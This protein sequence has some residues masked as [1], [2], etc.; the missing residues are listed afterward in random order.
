MLILVRYV[1]LGTTIAIWT[2]LGFLCWV[3]LLV[4]MTASF[5]VAILYCTLTNADSSYL[6]DPLDGAITFYSRGFSMIITIL[7]PNR[8][9]LPIGSRF[10]FQG[11]RVL[12]EIAWAV[13]FWASILFLFLTAFGWL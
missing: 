12:L 8:E 10:E 11:E 13:V 4:R 7:S 1:V 5:S 2:V 6:R 9:D 3:P